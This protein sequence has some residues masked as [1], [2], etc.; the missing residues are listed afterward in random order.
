MARLKFRGR[1][2]LLLA[3]FLL[4]V[5]ALFNL[6]GWLLYRRAASYLDDQLGEK[7]EAIAATAALSLSPDLV[8]SAQDP[9]AVFLLNDALESIRRE[10]ELEAVHLFD[11]GGLTLAST[12]RLSDYQV[13]DPAPALDH[14]AWMLAASGLPGASV[15]YQVDG[16][17][18]KSG[19]APVKDLA[20]EV[21]AVVAAEAPAGY[22]S[23]L[24]QFKRSMI[25]LGG[26]SFLFLAA[27][28]LLFFK[29]ND[30]LARA[31]MAVMRADALAT[32][33]RMA[34]HMAHEIRNPLGI[35][36][37][38]VQRL[39]S[40]PSAADKDRELL[41]F[42]PEEV[43]RLDRIVTRYL[44]FARV[45]PLQPTLEDPA[46]LADETVSMARRELAEE[47]VTV[48]LSAPETI[49][50]ILLDAH[51]IKQALL[52]LLLNAAQAMP[53]GGRIDVRITAEK[54]WVRIAVSDTGRGI[55]RGDLKVIFEPFYTTKERGSGLGLAL[56]AKVVE[57]H[58]GRIE[59][60]SQPDKGATFLLF[61]PVRS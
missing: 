32:L 31:E 38:A 20:G 16:F 7:L 47:G 51:R 58:Q 35:I 40:S 33:G 26:I 50:S 3:L 28:G 43:D 8:E 23:V 54:K 15:L 44:R 34:A 19:Y 12:S 37:G 30:S 24:E 48:E 22:F 60:R 18:L 29:L 17:Y 59:V 53:D 11:P 21:L 46:A 9:G 39:Q 41:G 25:A 1:Q 2:W 27:A 45:E 52:N 42:L 6:A 4:F 36:R 10:N 55:S 56:V 49:P 5:I 57:E 14:E 13:E 61:L